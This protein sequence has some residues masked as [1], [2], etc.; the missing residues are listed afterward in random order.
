VSRARDAASPDLADDAQA[1]TAPTSFTGAAG[2]WERTR[3]VQA[4]GRLATTIARL[5]ALLQARAS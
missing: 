2:A 3:R 5:G 4:G 1:G